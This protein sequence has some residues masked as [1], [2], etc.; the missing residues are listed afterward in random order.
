MSDQPTS[1]TSAGAGID[2]HISGSPSNNFQRAA[3]YEVIRQSE[4]PVFAN[5]ALPQARHVD[6]AKVGEEILRD[7]KR[8]AL[9]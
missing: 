7:Q 2:A 8:R 6:L 9:C 3:H 1:S 5:V 4:A